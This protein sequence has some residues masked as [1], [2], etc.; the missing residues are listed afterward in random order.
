M[1]IPSLHESCPAGE[2]LVRVCVRCV[3][4][5]C[6]F[7]CERAILSAQDPLTRIKV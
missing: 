4:I 6:V 2:S 1:D 7:V 3:F 5:C